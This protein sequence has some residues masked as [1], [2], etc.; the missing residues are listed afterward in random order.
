MYLLHIF[1]YK[2]AILKDMENTPRFSFEF[3][4]FIFVNFMR[5]GEN[6]SIHTW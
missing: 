3:E 6:I 2:R 1:K 4:H 5:C